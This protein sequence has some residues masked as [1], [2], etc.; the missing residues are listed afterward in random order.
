MIQE[1]ISSCKCEANYNY[2]DV[3]KYKKNSKNV[4]SQFALSGFLHDIYRKKLY[5]FMVRPF[6]ASFQVVS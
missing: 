6:T 3:D 1:P 2:W 5:P 4:P